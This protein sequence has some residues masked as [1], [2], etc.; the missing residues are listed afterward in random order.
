[1]KPIHECAV[2]KDGKELVGAF[3]AETNSCSSI[4][5]VKEPWKRVGWEEFE[6]MVADNKVQFLVEKDGKVACRYNDEEL[7][8]LKKLPKE[9]ISA[10]MSHYFDMDISFQARHIEAASK[11]LGIACAVA[12]VQKVVG[13]P[14][15]QMYMYG[16]TEFQVQMVDELSKVAG[17]LEKCFKQNVCGTSVLTIPLVTFEWMAHELAG[18]Y[19]MM[20]DTETTRFYV[21][22]GIKMP[23]IPLLL[24]KASDETV[25]FLLDGLDKITA[26]NERMINLR[27]SFREVW[28]KECSFDEPEAENTFESRE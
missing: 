6:R 25:L 13:I 9:F 23:R 4:D 18:K 24:G 11:C 21:E 26:K 8:A 27:K 12:S 5:I 2:I 15:V 19:R 17:S 10:T 1:M 7:S 20:F 3:V 16:N 14:T 28:D 22:H